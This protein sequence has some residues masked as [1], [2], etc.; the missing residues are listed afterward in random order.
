MVQNKKVKNKLPDKG[1]DWLNFSKTLT[2]PFKDP[3]KSAK[4]ILNGQDRTPK[5]TSKEL[6]FYN[7]FE[8][9]TGI[10][11]NFIYSYSFSLKPKNINLQEVVILVDLIINN[12]N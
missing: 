3:V 11:N 9:H 1:N 10:P 4:I 12:Y 6:K 7:L 5:F 8:K 2:Y